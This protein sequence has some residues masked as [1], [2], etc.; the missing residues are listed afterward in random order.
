LPSQEKKP[1][2]RDV[3]QLALDQRIVM[4]SLGSAGEFSQHH[5]RSCRKTAMRPSRCAILGALPTGQ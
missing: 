3:R 4:K 1:E 5:Q 2:R